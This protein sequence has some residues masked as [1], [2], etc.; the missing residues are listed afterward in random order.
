MNSHPE[1]TT[2]RRAVVTAA[3][4][5][6]AGL[7]TGSAAITTEAWYRL[8]ED[9]VGANNLPKDSS[10]NS[11]DFVNTAANPGG[12]T[13]STTSPAPG[14][15]KYYIFDADQTGFDTDG[16]TAPTD[17]IGV[18]CWAQSHDLSFDT[19]TTVGSVVFGTGDNQHGIGILYNDFGAGF[20]GVI[21]NV[22]YV[23]LP[24]QPKTTNDWVHFAVVRDSGVT[25]FYVNGVA[26][27]P[28]RTDTP[29]A[30]TGVF[31]GY[32]GTLTNFN[33]AIDE[34]RIFTFQPGEFYPNDLL[35]FQSTN[36][37]PYVTTL[38]GDPTG[39]LLQLQDK[40]TTVDTN[41]LAVQLDGAAVTGTTVTKTAGLTA[42]DYRTTN[43]LASGSSHSVNLIFAD[44]AGVYQTNDLSFTVSTYVAI[45]PTLAVP[46]ASVDT[47][48]PG[49]RLRPYQTDGSV[50]LGQQPN[51]LAWTEDQLI[52]L[53]GPNVADLSGADANGFYTVTGVI[54]FSIES[55]TGTDRG[56][57]PNDLPFPGIPGTLPTTGD[58]SF[59]AVTF[60]QFP[61][62]GVYTMGVNSDDGFKVTTGVNPRD[63]FAT[64]LG[65]YDG[66]R[67]S[68]DTIF[69]I[70]IPQAGFYP[71]RLLYENGNGELAGGNLANVE[72]FTVQSDGTKVLINDT[73]SPIKAYRQG[74][75]PPFVS[76]VVPGINAIGVLP[77]ATLEVDIT[78]DGTQVN[79]DSILIGLN[80][81]TLVAPTTVS[82]PG[83]VATATFAPTN[84]FAVS[85]VN[86]AQ[87]AWSDTGSYAI[88]N[89]WQFTVLNATL[90]LTLW[91]APGSGDSTKP[92]FRTHTWQ[93]NQFTANGTAAQDIATEVPVANTMLLGLWGTNI[94]DLSQAV[95]GEFVTT[96]AINWNYQA[97]SGLDGGIFTSDNGHP[98]SE[99]PGIPGTDVNGN[100]FYSD[101]STE[102]YTFIEFPTSGVYTMGVNSDDGFR[103]TCATNTGPDVGAVRVLAPAGIAGS[104]KCLATYAANGGLFGG[105]WTFTPIV[106]PL[107]LA[108][109]GSTTNNLDTANAGDSYTFM[110]AEPVNAAALKGNIAVTRRGG[111][112]PFAQKAKFA[113]D[114]GALAV[115][116]VDRSDLA[117][118][119]PWGMGGSDPSVTIPCIMVNWDVWATL[120]SY[121]T[122]NATTTQVTLSLGDDSSPLLG[123]FDGGRGA[124]A[125]PT[126]P[127]TLFSFYVPKAG[128]YPMRL[129]YFQ[130][131]GAASCE[132]FSLDKN[133]N[134]VL[135]NDSANSA[136]LK[137]YRA[138]TAAV[139]PTIS[140]AANGASVT[141][142]FT[143]TLQSAGDVAGTFTDVTATSPLNVP[144]SQAAKQ[145]YRA[146]Q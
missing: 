36:T 66:G 35:F 81:G 10:S 146:R 69:T 84:A 52:G 72:W 17:N 53:Y 23:G 128:V 113:Q 43:W 145:F 48:K 106:R 54:N 117:G 6:L 61:A 5:A 4:F 82:K 115:I 27:S 34:A 16:W 99:I 83:S 129:L 141:I 118:Q 8:G 44:S 49:F 134:P 55:G 95:N 107:V 111:G 14:S 76:R 112:I 70:T 100:P 105:P 135:L 123:Q 28:T 37:A 13:V 116:L 124:S 25:T 45:P 109:D 1:L 57:F 21:G 22:N 12:V 75:L 136:S 85:S 110:T 33:G 131:G 89:S 2:L 90:P 133:S 102:T 73:T 97:D 96:G 93:I 87:V 132:W 137:A 65:A 15:S 101:Y 77:T 80:G 39:F 40:N 122:T 32:G 92:G 71:F 60:L 79:K 62:A 19:S 125:D 38:K 78:D 30:S 143:G 114:A 138:R 59:E 47:T 144:V 108:D 24:Y 46:P 103:V 56:D 94:A 26:Q 64:V 41:T 67:G 139:A 88:T 31:M 98:D 9:G 68:A 29:V 18:E 50:A 63:R 142:T 104:Y 11:R 3:A 74:P 91:S 86:T 130:G 120:R 58:A 121:V 119:S 140:I 126:S 20:V 127:G 42:F 51:T 7:L